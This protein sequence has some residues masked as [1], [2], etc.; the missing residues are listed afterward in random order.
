MKRLIVLASLVLILSLL[1]LST[2]SCGSSQPDG[3]YVGSI[4]SNVYHYPDCR[5]AK[6]INP[7]NEIWF[8]SV[9]GAISKGYR[10]CEVCHPPSH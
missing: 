3:K 9:E 7:E 8:S 2:F 10:P 1:F 6:Q 5:F 4:N